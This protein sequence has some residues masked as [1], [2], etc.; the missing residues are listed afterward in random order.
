MQTLN[1][2]T[3][4]AGS[5]RKY[6]VPALVVG[7]IGIGTVLSLMSHRGP[8]PV[9]TASD[10]SEA[11]TFIV[12]AVVAVVGF[13]LYFLPAFAGR[14]KRNAAAIFALNLLLGWTLI[15]WVVALVW[16]LTVDAVVAPAPQMAGAK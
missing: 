15:G 2:N 3:D 8:V 13:L 16:A 11:S 9:A 5:H 6:V 14:S 10:A 7:A 1:S 4:A 12:M